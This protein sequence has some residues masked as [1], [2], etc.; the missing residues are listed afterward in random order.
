MVGKIIGMCFGEIFIWSPLFAIR[1]MKFP[2]ATRPRQNINFISEG[3]LVC[4]HM[5]VTAYRTFEMMQVTRV[6]QYDVFY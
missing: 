3:S 6:P 1:I 5:N 4:A 2:L